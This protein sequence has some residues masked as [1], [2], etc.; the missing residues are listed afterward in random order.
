MTAASKKMRE[1]HVAQFT[2][3]VELPLPALERRHLKLI[4][5]VLFLA[6]E[7]LLETQGSILQTV[8]EKELNALMESQLDEIREVRPDWA[9][10]VSGVSRGKESISFDGSSLEKRPD[11]SIHLT[12]RFFRLPLVIECKL[13]DVGAKKGVTLYCEQGLSRFID[14]QYGWYAVEAFMLAYVRDGASI[15]TSLTPHLDTCSKKVPD[16]YLTQQLPQPITGPTQQLASSS[17]G[18]NFLG[19]PGPIH[20][21]HLWLT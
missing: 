10:I 16:P 7:C 9:M 13:I 3:G 6:W 21:W 14:G 2:K 19:N 20:I 5:E 1:Y 11:L 12:D 17:H 18:R 15:F 8:E 4:A